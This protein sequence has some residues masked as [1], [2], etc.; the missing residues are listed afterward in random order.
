MHKSLLLSVAVMLVAGCF[1]RPSLMSRD[2]YDSVEIGMPVADLELIA[3]QPREIRSKGSEIEEYEYIERIKVQAQ[4][5]HFAVE[6]I[7]Y[8]DVLRGQVVG[9]HMTIHRT[10]A[11]N[12]LY[13]TQPNFAA[14]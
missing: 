8:I 10:P 3:G 9:K 4:P 13:D 6:N 2:V 14:P 7:Y 12:I 1:S 11:Y 5:D